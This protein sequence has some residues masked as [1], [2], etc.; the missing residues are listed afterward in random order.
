MAVR[1]QIVSCL[2]IRPDNFVDGAIIL[3]DIVSF[4]SIGIYD[5]STFN[6]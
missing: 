4:S 2:G 1:K 3:D 6:D 5:S